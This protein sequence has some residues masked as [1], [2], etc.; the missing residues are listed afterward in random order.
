MAN[1]LSYK[2]FLCDLSICNSSYFPVWFQ[3]H[4]FVSDC[5]N[6]FILLGD[7]VTE[8]ITKTCPCNI[9]QYFSAAKSFIFR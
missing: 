1:F 8:N 7:S 9:Q 4:D 3:W 5:F 6:F 2:C